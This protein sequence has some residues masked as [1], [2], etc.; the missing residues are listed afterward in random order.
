MNSELKEIPKHL[1]ELGLGILAQAQSNVFFRSW[2]NELDDGI[3]GLLQTAHS[4]EIII[5]AVIAEQHP[6]LIFSN[7]PKSTQVDEQLLDMRSIIEL[8]KTI[9]FLDLPEK[10]WATTGYKI[11]P[12]EQYRSFGKLRN[13]VQHFALP[14]ENLRLR[15]A[16]FIYEII[17]PILE[18][19]WQLYA[20]KYCDIDEE[21]RL[22]ESLISENIPFRF[23][24]IDQEIYNE[25]VQELKTTSY[26]RII[27][28]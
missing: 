19:F 4:C 28:V 26:K 7:L 10:L 3:F 13:C 18:H 1:K 11:E 24:P 23:D 16:K 25:I 17:D 21:Y 12:L 2:D 9:S 8:G 15:S 5:K 22:M 6:L 27:N 20:V 14:N